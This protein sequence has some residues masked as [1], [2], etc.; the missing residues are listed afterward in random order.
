[1]ARRDRVMRSKIHERVVVTMT[2]GETFDG[3]VY[4]F[5][6]RALVLMRAEAVDGQTRTRADGGLILP[7]AN[8]SYLQKP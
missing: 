5:D 4:D 8:V 1:M 6:E 2:S 3:L 7:W